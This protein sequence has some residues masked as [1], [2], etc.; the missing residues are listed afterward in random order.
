MRVLCVCV[1]VC[2]HF[3]QPVKVVECLAQL[4]HEQLD[5]LLRKKGLAICTNTQQLAPMKREHAVRCAREGGSPL[6]SS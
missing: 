6:M 3:L 2:V 5:S 1:C 4:V